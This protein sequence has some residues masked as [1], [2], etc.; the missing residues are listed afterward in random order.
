MFFLRFFRK[1]GKKDLAEAAM[2]EFLVL[3]GVERGVDGIDGKQ[4]ASEPGFDA[5][6][7]QQALAQMTVEYLGDKNLDKKLY[8]IQYKLG[9]AREAEELNSEDLKNAV[10]AGNAPVLAIDRT[11]TK[12]Y[13]RE[14]VNLFAGLMGENGGSLVVSGAWHELRNGV[15]KEFLDEL[16][17]TVP[18]NVRLFVALDQKPN[19]VFVG[20]P[21]AYTYELKMKGLNEV[22]SEHNPVRYVLQS[23]SNV[24]VVTSENVAVNRQGLDRMDLLNRAEVWMGAVKRILPEMM[25]RWR[26]TAE[27]LTVLAHQA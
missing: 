13:L 20:S 23:A 1:A 24:F 10:A 17:H 12:D 18:D 26:K 8:G 21:E 2:A 4:G 15:T 22:L 19:R 11:W 14:Q 7:F 16:Q 3:G 6:A 5:Q 9:T 27:Q 25:E